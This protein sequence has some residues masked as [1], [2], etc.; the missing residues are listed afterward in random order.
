[1]FG[2]FLMHVAKRG[3]E[4]LEHQLL[5][6]WDPE[7][8]VQEGHRKHQVGQEEQKT[9]LISF[10]VDMWRIK[11]SAFEWKKGSETRNLSWRR[12]NPPHT[13]ERDWKHPH[14]L[15]S[16]TTLAPYRT[17]TTGCNVSYVEN[18]AVAL[19]RFLGYPGLSVP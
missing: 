12:E 11:A 14:S 2:K 16:P 17:V 5:I 10:V 19:D 1:M 13:L 9:N 4:A 8:A 7:T 3:R 15:R 18:C 6:R